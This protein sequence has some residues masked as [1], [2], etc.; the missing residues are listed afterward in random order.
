[1]SMHTDDFLILRDYGCLC[2]INYSYE[3]SYEI[4]ISF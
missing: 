2:N 3:S 1:M 4:Y